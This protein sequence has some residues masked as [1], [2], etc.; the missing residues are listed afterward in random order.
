MSGIPTHNIFGTMEA[1]NSDPPE[2]PEAVGEAVKEAIRVGYRVIDTAELYQSK[3]QVGKA[4]AESGVARDELYIISKLGALPSGDYQAV[5]DR[6]TQLLKDLQVEYLDLLLIHWPGSLEVDFADFS[7]PEK[8]STTAAF[9]DFAANIQSAWQNI[10]QLR[11]EGLIRSAGVSNFY[12][13]HIDELLKHVTSGSDLPAANQIYIDLAHQ[14][15][16]FTEYLKSL[17]IQVIAYRSIAFLGV[18]E[19]AEES[20]AKLRELVGTY[21][22][23]SPQQLALAYFIKRGNHVVSKSSKPEHILSNF[24]AAELA[25]KSN[26]AMED[27]E[28]FDGEE[29]IELCGGVDDFAVGFKNQV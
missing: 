4:I 16:E 3:Q 17:H 12:K 15:R 28:C 13:Q 9:S 23:S 14:E 8:L 7:G 26:F 21:G 2:T 20:N 11:T 18:Y 5:K 19:L 25:E 10:L 27:F 6:T 1:S 29:M 22:A 24:K